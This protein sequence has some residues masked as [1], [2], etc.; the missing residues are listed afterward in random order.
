MQR[1][2]WEVRLQPDEH[3]LV[4]PSR[5][6]SQ[7]AWQ[8]N[9]FG[10]ERIPIV[11]RNI[12]SGWVRAD[13]SAIK[14]LG[15]GLEVSSARGND[16]MNVPGAPK[17]SPNGSRRDIDLPLAE[18][19]AV[20]SSVGVPGIA[21]IWIVQTWLLVFVLSGPV[22]ALGLAFIYVPVMRQVPAVLS[23]AGCVTVLAAIWCN[24]LPLLA[25][26]ALPGFALSFLAAI[27]HAFVSHAPVSARPAAVVLPSSSLTRA[28]P[29]GQVII[30]R[31]SIRSQE[32]VAT[33]GR[34]AS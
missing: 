24:L 5:W 26:A 31:S 29:L 23:I 20:Y 32:S 3:I 15:G 6:S 25:Q 12:L 10:L 14:V 34:S 21:R 11:S 16:S 13:T 2:Y 1:F 7:Q 28:L 9:R 22:L 19:R 8:W 4:P 33:T 30:A 18:G 27:L 17:G